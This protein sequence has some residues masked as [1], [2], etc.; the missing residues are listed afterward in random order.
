MKIS[1][2]KEHRA[3]SVGRRAKYFSS[4]PLALCSMLFCL[5]VF[6]TSAS[7]S[8]A[9]QDKENKNSSIEATAAVNKS[10][11]QIG[12]K[13][14]YTITVRAKKDIEVEFP[15]ILTQ[16]LAGFAIKDFGLSQ[17]SL[18]GKKTFKQ[19]YLLD[20]YVSGEHTIPSAAIKYRAKGQAD[21]QELRVKEVKVEVKSVL[22]TAPVR[23]DIRDIRGPKSFD[24]KMRLYMLI[25]IVVLLITGA[26]FG[27][28]LFKKKKEENKALPAL[29]HIVAYEALAALE[30]KDYI[31]KGQTKTYYIELSGIVRHYLENRFNIRA[32]EMTTE[33]FLI[34]VKVDSALSLEHKGL[35][36]DFLMNCDLVKFAKYQPAEQEANLSLAS[37]KR[38]IDQT[39]EC[40]AES[41]GQR[42]NV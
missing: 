33:E 36:R 27:F 28:L 20:T 13:I 25:A 32:S 41:I 24:S 8:Y 23:T 15:Q 9:A 21:W 19:W 12:D 34:K 29:A 10:S 7:V 11:M 6:S 18:F 14:T 38:L 42:E 35:L 37:A 16:E 5:G 2:S 40:R 1:K 3:E 30:K 4:M 39:K 26:V 31:R 22:D 17:K